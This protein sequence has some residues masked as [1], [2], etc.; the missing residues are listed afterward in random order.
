MARPLRVELEGGL[1]HVIAR[2]N[3]RRNV[4]RDDADRQRYLDRLAFYAEK[5][6]FRVVAYCL[7]DN[8]V[9][10][11]ILRGKVPL[12]KI[13]AGLQ[14]SYTQYFNRRH[15]RPGHLFQG[16]YK[17]FLVERDRYGLALLRYIHENPVK[18]R[19]VER[20]ENFGWSSD[21]HYR[22]GRGPD[23][24]DLD[25]LLA[26]L[27]GRRTSAIREYRR[28][29]RESLQ[30]PYDA[31]A[32]WGQA[33]K[34]DEDFAD[35]V[36][37]AAGEPVIVPRGMTV[38]RIARRVARE[39]EMDAGRMRGP[40]RERDVSRA[41]LMVAWLGREVGRIPVA[42]TARFFSRDTSTMINGVNR[43][44]AAMAEDRG[45]RRRLGA[46]RDSLGAA[47]RNNTIRKD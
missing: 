21:R 25:L 19:L 8:H 13:M 30:E 5:Y 32:S 11:A 22:R 28:L 43:L 40:G 39:Q 7:M 42:Q 41:R 35:R 4:F 17:A 34:G 45:L 14:S 3:E 20:A 18:A 24:M 15:G 31:V 38:E 46:L 36:L 47:A 16:R 29:M 2:G 44:E 33:V 9:H 10:L 37:R 12:S 26:M 27:N 6:S 1:Y 23:W